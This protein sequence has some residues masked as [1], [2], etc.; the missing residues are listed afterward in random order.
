MGRSVVDALVS[1]GRIVRSTTTLLLD[2]CELCQTKTTPSRK[3]VVYI[4]HCGHVF[5]HAC[6]MEEMLS[7]RQTLGPHNL[8]CPICQEKLVAKV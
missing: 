2:R 5:H 1:M 7:Q 4:V 3:D 6:M 8:R